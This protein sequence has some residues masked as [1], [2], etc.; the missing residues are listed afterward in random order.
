MTIFFHACL[1]SGCEAFHCARIRAFCICWAVKRTNHRARLVICGT[2]DNGGTAISQFDQQRIAP[3]DAV[4][5]D[6]HGGDLIQ[7]DAAK[8]RAILFDL[9]EAAIP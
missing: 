6:D 3:G 1:T 9:H 7:R 8:G 2:K 4:G 5:M